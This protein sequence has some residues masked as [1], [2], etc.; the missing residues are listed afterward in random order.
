MVGVIVS[1]TSPFEPDVAT[2]LVEHLSD[3][4]AQSPPESVH[5]LAAGALAKDTVT[6]LAARDEHGTLLGIGALA[7]LGDDHGE[8]K[9]MRTVASQRGKGVAATVLGALLA[10]A[11]ERGY[12]RVSLETGSMDFFAPARR[13]YERHGFVP[14]EPFGDYWDD[15]ASAFFTLEL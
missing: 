1:P 10:L 2:L 4:H 14:C 9:S 8:I 12:T 5:A 13:L 3:M 7:A 6:L 15:P 11:R